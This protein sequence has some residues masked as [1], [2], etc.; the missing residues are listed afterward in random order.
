VETRAATSPIVIDPERHTLLSP[1]RF[2]Y[3]ALQALST[4]GVTPAGSGP[5][6]A[7]PFQSAL[8]IHAGIEMSAKIFE[9]LLAEVVVQIA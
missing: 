6:R 4:R 3:A 1:P 2:G 9:L 7:F 8:T 5:A